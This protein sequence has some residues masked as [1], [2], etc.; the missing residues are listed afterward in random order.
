[1]KAVTTEGSGD[2]GVLKFADIEPPQ[3]GPDEIL[4]KTWASGLN[5]AD[6]MQ[7][8]G[9]YPPPTGVSP[10]LGLE[11]SGT[12]ESLGAKAQGSQLKKGDSVIALLAGGGYAENVVIRYDQ[13]MSL[14][15]LFDLTEAGGIA[16]VFLTAYLELV[17]LGQLQKGQRLLIHAGASG[18]GTAA[19]QIAKSLG[20]EIWVTASSDKKLQFCQ[21]LGAQH[22]INYKTDDFAKVIDEHTQGQGV[23]CILDLVGAAHFPNNLKALSIEGKLLL[24]GMGGGRKSEVDLALLISKRLHILGSTLRSRAL[25]EKACLIKEFWDFAKP[26]FASGEFRPI[27][28]RVFPAKEVEAAHTF[29]ETQANIGKI[30][31]KW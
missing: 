9:F 5:G 10:L 20:A 28:D 22:L 3:P 19:I 4:I 15:P 11:V 30:V 12:V 8:R 25:D 2:V 27:I 23:N 1:M 24:V 17:W 29:M 26:K 14:P 16:E 7:R 18:V 21:S 13:V 6:L 31:L